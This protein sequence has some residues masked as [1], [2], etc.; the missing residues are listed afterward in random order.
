MRNFK[1]K[2]KYV[3]I[4]LVDREKVERKTKSGLLLLDNDEG[5]T[6]EY[7]PATKN[8]VIE[9]VGPDVTQVKV[10]EYVIF[11]EY[12]IKGIKDDDNNHF[13][14]CKEESIFATYED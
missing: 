3:L 8:F 12:D 4:K 7:T 10:G 14:L 5:T 6:R 2:G 9:A 1:P 11:N 13:A